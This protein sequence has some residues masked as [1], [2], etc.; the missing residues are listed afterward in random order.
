VARTREQDACPGT[1]LSYPAADGALVRIRL[2]GGVIRAAQLAIL[3]STAAT[4]GSGTLELTSRGGL[5]LRGITDTTAVAAAVADAGLLPS[6]SHD[7]VRNIVSSPLSGRSGGL[8]DVRPWVRGLDAAIQQSPVLATL[9]GRFL[10][11][12]DDGRGDVSGIGADVGVQVLGDSVA[13]LMDGKDTGVRFAP[14]QAVPALITVATSFAIRRGKAWRIRELPDHGALLSH[15][16]PAVSK[17]QAL[18]TT[19]APPVGWFEQG[20]GRISLGAVTPLGVLPVHAAQ[21]L[22]DLETSL[23]ITPWRSILICDL[24]CGVAVDALRTLPSMGLIFDKKSNWVTVSACVGSQGCRHSA[25]DVRA[26]AAAAVE[27]ATGQRHRQ[28]WVGCARACG[29]PLVGEVLVA[30]GSGY[31]RLD[32]G[33]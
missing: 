26:D 24:P 22:A 30:T 7:R 28:H 25:A 14:N 13:F 31:Q 2:P 23:V 16:H 33:G 12:I 15:L 3:A 27:S 19:T 20:D 11:S 4:A 17:G 29:S 10:F 6:V 9:P 18:F 5:Q 8:A 21:A 32:N 1:L